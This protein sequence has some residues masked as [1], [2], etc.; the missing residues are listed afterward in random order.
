[1]VLQDRSISRK[2]AVLLCQGSS[3]F[4]QDLGSTNGISKAGKRAERIELADGDEFRLGDLPLRFRLAHAPGEEDIEFELGSSPSL[5]PAPS[6]APVPPPPPVRAS[7]ASAEAEVEIEI[8]EGGEIEIEGPDRAISPPASAQ[9]A[10]TFRPPRPARRTGLFSSEL[11]QMPLWMRMLAGLVLLALGA[12]L[13]YGAFR[14][15]EMLR[16]G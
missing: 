16:A 7:A 15:V 1:V 3:W 14:V 11:E 8:E 4:V 9:A 5:P 12:G 2:H 13:A 6:A 10:T